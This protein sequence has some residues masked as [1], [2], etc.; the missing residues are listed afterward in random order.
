M[1]TEAARHGNRSSSLCEHYYISASKC[2]EP[3]NARSWSTAVAA[4]II[5][6]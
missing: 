2:R 1:V 5:V 4:N 3:T 6:P